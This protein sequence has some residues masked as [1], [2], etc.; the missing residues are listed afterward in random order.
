[1]AGGS[2]KRDRQASWCSKKAS[3]VAMPEWLRGLTRNQMGFPRAGSNPAGDAF[4]FYNEQLQLFKR[5]EMFK[6]VL[7]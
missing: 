3:T 1:M 5:W 4:K 2:K 7:L 6:L